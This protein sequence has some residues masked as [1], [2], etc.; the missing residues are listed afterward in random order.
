[1]EE[2]DFDIGLQEATNAKAE[3]KIIFLIIGQKY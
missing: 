3:I 2:L 1:M